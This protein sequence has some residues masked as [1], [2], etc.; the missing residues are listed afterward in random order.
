MYSPTAATRTSA[1]STASTPKIRRGRSQVRPPRPPRPRPPGYRPGGAAAGPRG[2]APRPDELGGGC[3]GQALFGRWAP[4]EG[5]RAPTG[6]STVGSLEP[7]GA[8][9]R[10][11][12]R[13]QPSGHSLMLP[14]NRTQPLSPSSLPAVRASGQIGTSVWGYSG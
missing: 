14:S 12:S 2:A 13:D 4:G 11:A 7:G 9:L 6:R 8:P 10:P 5:G 1:T 3:W